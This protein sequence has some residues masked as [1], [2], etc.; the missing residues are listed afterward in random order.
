MTL[1]TGLQSIAELLP[2]GIRQAF[3]NKFKSID[4]DAAVAQTRNLESEFSQL[5]ALQLKAAFAE[6]R[7]SCLLYTSP[8]PRDQR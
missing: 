1:A 5:D 3:S 2:A 6:L 8:S 4:L 7:H